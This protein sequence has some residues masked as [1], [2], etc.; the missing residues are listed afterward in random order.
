ME[1]EL[2]ISLKA[3]VSLADYFVEPDAQKTGCLEWQ[4]DREPPF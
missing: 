3:L 4:S 1:A 2:A